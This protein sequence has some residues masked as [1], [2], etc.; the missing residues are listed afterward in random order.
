[1]IDTHC[2]LT[3]PQLHDQLAGVLHR[4]ELAG[5]KKM[6]TIGTTPD[7][8]ERAV[9]LCARHTH[10]RAAVGIHPHYAA[11]ATADDLARI[12]ALESNPCVVALGEMGLDYHHHFSPR[13]RQKQ[14]FIGQLELAQR[15]ARPI[16]IHCRE[17]MEDCLD[18][19]S[20]Y[21]Q[22]R[23]VFHCF[24]GTAPEARRVLDRGYLIGFTGVVT[25]KRSDELRQ[26]AKFA[27]QEQIVV[28]TDAPYLTPEPH[29]TIKTNEPAMVVHTAAAVARERG[30]STAE[31]DELTTQNAQRFFVG[32]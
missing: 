29:R 9:D 15:T 5:V 4:A 28:E 7:D 31:L 8:A 10:I 27:P 16:V 22:I 26:V 24:T 19:L 11:Q 23:A 1:V 20:E 21:P 13:D 30:I 18:I 3:Y 14:I 17:A 32:L 6:V 2:H 25:F 12:A